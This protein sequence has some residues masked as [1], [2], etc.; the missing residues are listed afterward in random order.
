[1]DAQT[2]AA[3]MPGLSL[4]RAGQ[5]VDGA[6]EAL[7]LIGATD[8]SKVVRAAHFLAQLGHESVSLRY[9]EEIAS[10]SAYEG[11]A[12]LGNTQ[13]GDGVRFKGRSFIQ[14][15]GRHNYG[16]F[17]EWAAGQKLVP[18]PRYF[19]DHAGE[20]SSDRW[21][22]IGSTWYW[23]TQRPLNQLADA[24]DMYGVTRAIN[25]GLNGLDDRVSRY[26]HIRT[27]GTAI[28]PGAAPTPDRLLEDDMSSI[29]TV[30]QDAE[31]G[32]GVGAFHPVLGARMYSA[33]QWA[34][35]SKWRNALPEDDRPPQVKLAR[36]VW[37]DLPPHA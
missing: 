19:L 12:D 3:A 34:A 10:G 21:A 36:S 31:G 37:N 30:T 26:R 23:L 6:N 9:T 7:R 22:W 5:L 35:V 14:I 8:A 16:R 4:A 33:S 25:G 20:L 32:G 29:V 28:L 11:R 1:M 17:S 27:L 13:P 2:L 24:D 18:S 15:T